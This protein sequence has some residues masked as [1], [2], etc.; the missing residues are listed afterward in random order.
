[1]R[2]TVIPPTA[3]LT[4]TTA[5][6][7]MMTNFAKAPKHMKMTATDTKL[8][9]VPIAREHNI[10]NYIKATEE[11]V[12]FLDESKYLGNYDDEFFQQRLQY[13]PQQTIFFTWSNIILNTT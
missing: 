6:K 9:T 1:M 2:T 4:N 7:K 11:E 12:I 5:Q 8:E 10:N 3:T 13:Y